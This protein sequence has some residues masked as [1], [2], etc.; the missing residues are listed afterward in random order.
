MG[1]TGKYQF[2][3]IR[4]PMMNKSF[5]SEEPSVSVSKKES[6][7]SR[8]SLKNLVSMAEVY[9]PATIDHIDSKKGL[10]PNQSRPQVAYRTLQ[11][12]TMSQ[13]L[14]GLHNSMDA[15][16][17]MRSTAKRLSSVDGF[18]VKSERWV[19]QH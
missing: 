6:R 17:S 7:L 1:S 2:P 8:K 15:S 16:R 11:P 19:L 3:P 5:S 10:P 18:P 13:T 12:S 4:I 9:A 14:P